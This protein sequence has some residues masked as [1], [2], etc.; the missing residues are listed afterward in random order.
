VKNNSNQIVR[1]SD[2]NLL[3][4]KERKLIAVILERFDNR[5]EQYACEGLWV[6]M[7]LEN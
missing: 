2:I 1:N 5:G 4:K 6:L 3:K 7:G